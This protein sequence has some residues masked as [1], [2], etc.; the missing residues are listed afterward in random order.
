MKLALD[1]FSKKTAWLM[2]FLGSLMTFTVLTSFT[3][4]VFMIW[5]NA[6]WIVTIPFFVFTLIIN[7]FTLKLN[8][9]MEKKRDAKT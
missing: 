6:F 4:V 1:P 2:M 5:L 3:L 8:E 7:V 9:V